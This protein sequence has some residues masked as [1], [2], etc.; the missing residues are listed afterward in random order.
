VES[1]IKSNGKN[2]SVLQI[3][4]FY[5]ATTDKKGEKESSAVD[6]KDEKESS[7]IEE[8]TGVERP[9]VQ[10]NS[11]K[12]GNSYVYTEAAPGMNSSNLYM[13]SIFSKNANTNVCIIFLKQKPTYAVH[14]KYPDSEYW[15]KL[16]YMDAS[17]LNS[18]LDGGVQ[19]NPDS[20]QESMAKNN[21]QNEAVYLA[22]RYEDIFG[23]NTFTNF[24]TGE[25]FERPLRLLKQPLACVSAHEPLARPAVLSVIVQDPVDPR[26]SVMAYRVT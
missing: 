11:H 24:K 10:L 3:E 23:K 1:R 22:K 21:D 7:A 9:L 26:V 12:D 2:A 20:K 15:A 19:V 5:A 18:S 8:E 4:R 17:S 6:K 13:Y 25:L 14:S 16:L